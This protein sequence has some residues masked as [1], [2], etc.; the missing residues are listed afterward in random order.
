MQVSDGEFHGW[1]VRRAGYPQVQIL[2]AFLRLEKEDDVAGMQFGE[3]VEQKVIPR[4]FLAGVQL[5]LLVGMGQKRA[6]VIEEIT[7]SEE[8]GT[9]EASSSIMRVFSE[10]VRGEMRRIH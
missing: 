10:R 2:S 1:S 8:K 5:V 9:R 3:G 6:D 7:M 4:G